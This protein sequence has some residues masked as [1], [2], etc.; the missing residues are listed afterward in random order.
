MGCV[1]GG[2]G[3][4][5]LLPKSTLS[6]VWGLSSFFLFSLLSF[7]LSLSLSIYLYIYP[8]FFLSLGPGKQTEERIERKDRKHIFVK[9]P[10]LLDVVVKSTL[11]PLSPFLL[12]LFLFAFV[13]FLLPFLVLKYPPLPF[14]LFLFLSRHLPFSPPGPRSPPPRILPLVHPPVLAPPLPHFLPSPHPSPFPLTPL[15]LLLLP[16]R[17]RIA[18]RGGDTAGLQQPLKATNT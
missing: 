5:R 16:C 14:P 7:S 11:D 9:T 18:K 10:K 4:R 13:I 6:N 12:L 17:R 8:S 15:L 2:G 1:W 3:R